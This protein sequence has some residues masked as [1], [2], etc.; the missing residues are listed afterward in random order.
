MVYIMIYK[1]CHLGPLFF[2]SPFQK[3]PIVGIW[4]LDRCYRKKL[5]CQDYWQTSLIQSAV[6]LVGLVLHPNTWVTYNWMRYHLSLNQCTGRLTDAV[7]QHF[8]GYL[9]KNIWP[10]LLQIT[11]NNNS[12]KI[13]QAPNWRFLVFN[14]IVFYTPTQ[15]LCYRDRVQQ[16]ASQFHRPHSD[17][18]LFWVPKKA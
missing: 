8:W 4:T 17:N 11:V 1:I 7:T 16:L 15:L 9:I 10:F 6:T 14:Q 2:N 5:P 13:I 18:T 12:N 3:N